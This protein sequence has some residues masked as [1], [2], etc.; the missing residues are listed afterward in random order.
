MFRTTYLFDLPLVK[1]IEV[2]GII[3]INL[4]Y[5]PQESVSEQQSL[6]G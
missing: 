3:Y 4:A 1:Q 6:P 5:V 2:N